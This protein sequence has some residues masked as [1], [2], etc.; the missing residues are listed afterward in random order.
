VGE[1]RRLLYLI[2]DPISARLLRGQLRFLVDRGFEVHVGSGAGRDLSDFAASEGVTLHTVPFVRQPRPVADLRALVS[3]IALIRSI[4]PDLV[5]AASPKAGFVGMV[6]ARLCRVPVRV[7]GVWGLRFETMSGVGR[8]LLRA[9]ERVAIAAATHAVFTSR[10]LE[11][12]AVAEGLL[13]AGAGIV[14]GAGASRGVDLTRV[15]TALA[16]HDARSLL[17][18]RDDDRVIGF[19]GRLTRDKGIA[20]LVDAAARLM[21]DRPD[22]RLLLVG[23]FEEGDPVGDIVRSRIADDPVIVQTGWLEDT[24]DVYAAMDVLA[25]PSYREGLPNVPLEAQAAGVPVVGYAA[26]GTVDAVD[27]GETG[28]LV[29]VG[30][31]DGLARALGDVLDD[32]DRAR[33]MGSRGKEWVREHFSS[34]QVSAALADCYTAWLEGDASRA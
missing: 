7:F 5:N 22:V 14:I 31:V 32:P 12:A 23:E 10:S 19:V 29:P 11:R 18:L 6:A 16:R 8:R 24:G 1:R 34:D 20:D 30:D 9:M 21:D 2:T 26:T 27:P 3:C 15:E 25:F 17:G 33:R 28:V 4:R 13:P